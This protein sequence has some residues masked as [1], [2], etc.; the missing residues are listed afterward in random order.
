VGV[1]EGGGGCSIA[2]D[3]GASHM[4]ASTVNC[5]MGTSAAC[6]KM[7]DK[8]TWIVGGRGGVHGKLAYTTDIVR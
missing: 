6:R 5:A 4:Q 2:H 1:A 8:L 3:C 7:C